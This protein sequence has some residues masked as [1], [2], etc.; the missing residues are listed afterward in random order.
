MLQRISAIIDC[1]V[2]FRVT[3]AILARDNFATAK[4]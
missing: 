4:L 1:F 2:L 3:D